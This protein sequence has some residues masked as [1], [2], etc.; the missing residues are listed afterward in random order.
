MAGQF[1]VSF[2]LGVFLMLLAVA[3]ILLVVTSLLSE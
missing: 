3:V 1:D 2:W